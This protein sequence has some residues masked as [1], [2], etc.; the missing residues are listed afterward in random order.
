[1]KSR[2]RIQHLVKAFWRDAWVLIRQFLPSLLAFTILVV[3][4]S[5]WLLFF[6]GEKR[7][8]LGESVYGTLMLVFLNPTLDFPASTVA[9]IPFFMV[10]ILGVG[11]FSEAIIRFGILLFAK[12]Y[13]QEEWQKVL[14][15]TYRG[16]TVVAGIGRVGFRA[17]QE[18]LSLGNEVVAI[19]L[20]D[21]EETA[22]LI[23]LLRDQ[24]VPVLIGDARR[25]EVQKD[26]R[27]DQ[28]RCLLVCTGNDLTNLEIALTARE[29]NSRLRIV[30]RLFSDALAERAAKFLGIDVAVSTS[31]LAAPSM[32]ASAVRQRTAHAFYVGEHLFHIAELLVDEG[33]PL[34]GQTVGDLEERHHISVVLLRRAEGEMVHHPRP[35]V[36]LKTNDTVVLIGSPERVAAL[37]Q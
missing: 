2:H 22:Y 27:I 9:R 13:R 29:I 23:Q 14:A 5:L 6:Y 18:L 35:E 15:S 7:L 25:V 21:D 32:V 36:P 26:A 4:G 20:S 10:P 1:M 12:S 28:A 31:A 11:I 24:G 34:V 16:H 30:V 3:T 19:S 33:S 37:E 17:C 8:D